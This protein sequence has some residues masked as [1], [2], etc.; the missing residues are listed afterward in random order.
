[1]RTKLGSGRLGL[2]LLVAAMVGCSQ[3]DPDESPAVARGRKIYMN[4]CIQCHASDPTKDGAVGPALAGSSL[5]L[6]DAR[7][8]RGEYPPGYTPKRSSGAMPQF[9]YL[10]DQI[11]DLA[12]YLAQAAED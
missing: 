8:L 4:V 5:E 12:A 6:L 2:A 11:G 3:G 7:V 1:L 9:P 10:K